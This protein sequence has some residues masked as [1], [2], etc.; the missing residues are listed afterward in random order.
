M[1]L[2]TNPTSTWSCQDRAAHAPGLMM[3]GRSAARSRPRERRPLDQ[4]VGAGQ[5]DRASAIR[6]PG[7]RRD[8]RRESLAS[9]PAGCYCRTGRSKLKMRR[10]LET[11]ADVLAWC[12]HRGRHIDFDTLRPTNYEGHR[13]DGQAQAGNFDTLSSSC[14]MRIVRPAPPAP[15]GRESALPRMR[16]G[17]ASGSLS[18]AV[19]V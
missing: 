19:R 13:V 14:T 5:A 2:L 16:S 15:A 1:T 12:L 8:P 10:T 3:L 9:R 7:G 6:P 18:R 11:M 4:R 17:R